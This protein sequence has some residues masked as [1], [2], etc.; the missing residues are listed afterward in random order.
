MAR[1]PQPSSLALALALALTLTLT[2]T[3]ALTLTLTRTRTRTR[4]RT[5]TRIRSARAARCAHCWL[6]TT[7]MISLWPR[8]A[9]HQY[10]WQYY[11]QYRT[12]RCC[13]AAGLRGWAAGGR[14]GRP[15]SLRSL[16]SL[17]ITLAR[18]RVSAL[19]S[20]DS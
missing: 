18:P 9:P 1:R 17:S 16:L 15:V 13:L 4:T 11:T 7:P 3:L 14:L 20:R 2:L 6:V 5:L 8:E 12:R 10:Y 19:A